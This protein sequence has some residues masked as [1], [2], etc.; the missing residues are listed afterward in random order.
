MDFYKKLG[1]DGARQDKKA[2]GLSTKT[3]RNYHNLLN[4]MLKDAVHWQLI[5]FNPVERIEPPKA[6]RPK[7]NFY[8]DEQCIQLI[9]LLYNEPIK[10]RVLIMICIYSGLRRGE[11]LGLEWSKIDFDNK[12]L[13]IEKTINYTKSKG[14][15]EKEPKT[16]NGIRKIAFS[17]TIKDILLEYKEWQEEYINTYNELYYDSG[18]LFTQH[19][20]KPMSPDTPS[21]W[22]AKFIAKNNLLPITLH[23][24]R[25]SNASILIASGLNLRTISTRLGH[26]QPSFTIGTYGHMLKKADYAAAD[27]IDELLKI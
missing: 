26:S 3:I 14:I 13:T 9:K 27:K 21:Q 19:N 23:G 17:D 4:A 7:I 15:Y 20:G 12:I 10:Y 2:G 25:H 8:D 16:D 1:T 18:K 22:F 5:A 11:V 6:K 24:L